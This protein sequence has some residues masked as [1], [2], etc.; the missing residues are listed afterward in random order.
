MVK[1]RA[2]VS[3]DERLELRLDRSFIDRPIVTSIGSVEYILGDRIKLILL[4]SRLTRVHV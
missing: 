1:R 4:N 3:S 2:V